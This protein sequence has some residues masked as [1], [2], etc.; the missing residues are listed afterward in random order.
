[1]SRGVRMLDGEPI[2][3]L[4]SPNVGFVIMRSYKQGIES[5]LSKYREAI[6]N[7]PHHEVSTAG[8]LDYIG[9]IYVKPDAYSSDDYRTWSKIHFIPDGGQLPEGARI[10]WV[11]GDEPPSEEMWRE[12]RFRGRANAMFVRYITATPLYRSQWEWLRRDFP[13]EPLIPV[14]NRI[15]VLSTVYDNLALSYEHIEQLEDLARGDSLEAARLKGEFVDIEGKCPFPD[16]LLKRW[17]GRIRKGTM[18]PVTIQKELDTED[19]RHLVEVTTEFEQFETFDLEEVYLG[20]IDPSLGI[21]DNLHDPACIHIYARRRPRLVARWNGYLPGGAT[22]RLAVRMANRYGRAALDCDMTGGYGESVINALMEERYS[23]VV[24][25]DYADRPGTFAQRLGF[26]ISAANRM[27]IIS[28]IQQA[29]AEDSVLVPSMEVIEC[30]KNVAYDANDK[31]LAVAGQHDEDMICLG[32]ACHLM[33]TRLPSALRKPK[34][35][36]MRDLLYQAMGMTPP[37]KAE[38]KTLEDFD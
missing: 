27:E 33:R 38:P 26:R 17:S 20:V 8:K 31:P 5:V 18:V 7:H 2:P 24:M 32:R 1:M 34:K 29:L 35:T 6:G 12:V 9:V 15:T 30:L 19:G 22:G 37:K 21:N 4:P 3:E 10:D 14:G 36:A 16:A 11:H 23:N 28:A 13:L 25:D